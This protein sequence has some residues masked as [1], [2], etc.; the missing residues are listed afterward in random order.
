MQWS[1]I[2]K[3]GRATFVHFYDN[4]GTLLSASLAFYS[5]LSMAPLGL[6]AVSVAGVLFGEDAATGELSSRM[7]PYVGHDVAHSIGAL[8]QQFS[9]KTASTNATL[10]GFALLLF[11]ASR[12]FSEIENAI[13][14][15]WQ[16]RTEFGSI[17]VGVLTTVYKKL[18]AFALVFMLGGVLS[19]FIVMST[20]VTILRRSV[21]DV[22]PGSDL[23]WAASLRL[24]TLALISLIFALLYRWLPDATVAWRDA[25][26]GST[27]AALVFSLAEWPMSFYLSHQGVAS[28]Y[29][30]MGTFVVFLLWI[31]YSAQI[32]F[33]GAQLTRVYADSSGRGIRPDRTATLVRDAPLQD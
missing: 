33:L 12:V 14:Q 19:G 15:L 29:G 6:V 30:A 24:G 26:V 32:F 18:V 8:I 9:D 3:L 31:Y 2:I 17:R 11:G 10:L 20:V 27:T 4:G 23:V 1:N 22:L 13:N 28:S 16:V 25:F 21:G 7:T 5:L